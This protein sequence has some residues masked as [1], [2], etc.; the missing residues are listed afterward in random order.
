MN[1]LGFNILHRQM[2]GHRHT[3]FSQ[4]IKVLWLACTLLF[5][6]ILCST[7]I[8]RAAPNAA[9]TK[10]AIL[11]G[12]DQYQN[13]EIS[14]LR[15]AVADTKAMKDALIGAGFPA[16]NVFTMTGDAGGPDAPTSLNVIKR[17][18]SLSDRIGP[19]DTFVFYFSGHGYQQE[20]GHFLATI[21]ADPTGPDTL[22]QSTLPIALLKK[23][24]ARIQA[25][26][27]IFI[28]DACRNDPE[29]GK[30]GGN[31]TLTDSFS[32]DL[33][34]VA[35]STAGGQSGSAVLLAC[36][37][38]QRAWEWPEKGHGV[39]TYYLMEG[40][41]GAAADARGEVTMNELGDYVQTQVANWSLR[42]FKKQTPDLQQ[43]GAA[44]IVMAQKSKT[45]ILDS[46]RLPELPK[47]EAPKSDVPK[48]DVPKPDVPKEADKPVVQAVDE[49]PPLPTDGQ[50]KDEPQ[51]LP[52]DRTAIVREL[53]SLLKSGGTFQTRNSKGMNL[54]Y[55]QSTQRI[56]G[57]YLPVRRGM[58]TAT[59]PAIAKDPTLFTDIE[60]Y[61][62]RMDI[63]QVRVEADNGNAFG[64]VVLKTLPNQQIKFTTQR[65]PKF[66]TEVRI[67]LA[68]MPDAERFA[69][70]FRQ[71]LKTY[72]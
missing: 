53:T 46:L 51:P 49:A 71:L 64:Y 20:A 10:W 12:I 28:I 34:L 2:R 17:L 6:A 41:K 9:P 7:S 70:L 11:V 42:N 15:Y 62:T 29:R 44:K 43:F 3:I 18:S 40:L 13:D 1:S 36:S 47:P 22:E 26:R 52:T 58:S 60:I 50:I 54:S 59:A 21:D 8:V 45:P 68:T 24:M 48:P 30:G 67:A 72:Q 19:D 56:R 14:T 55:K 35:K 32:R 39:F 23:R 4:R 31:N 16:S 69:A 38:G 65:L 63:T 33:Q 66:D 57:G 37:E 5:C 25:K 61:P 27:A